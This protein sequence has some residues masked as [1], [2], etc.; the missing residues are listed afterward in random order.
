VGHPEQARPLEA[1][2]TALRRLV[3]RLDVVAV[4]T[5]RAATD[6]RD[7]LGEVG[8][9]LLIVGNHGV[10]W[11]DP[12]A[13]DPEAAEPEPEAR[14]AMFRALARLP[15]IDGV[16]VEGKDP[17]A[18]IHYRQARNPAAAREAIIAAVQKVVGPEL[19][20]REGRLHVELRPAG[21]PGK[22][23]AVRRIV[24]RHGL[25]GLLVAGDDVT[26]LDMFLAA[27]GLV[28]EAGV[29]AAVIAIAGGNE[30]PA[31]VAAA[32]DAV[33]A[34]PAAFAELLGELAN[35]LA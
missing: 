21:L 3:G 25:T 8:R 10:E 11:L 32:A 22:G 20:I 14:D 29:S 27:R 2:V 16:T 33:L 6:A 12:A 7:L 30:V 31:P 4:V 5:G 19:E 18:T 15:A 13:S 17:A 24:E 34:D 23:S 26:D 35:E 28:Q 9:E 1:A